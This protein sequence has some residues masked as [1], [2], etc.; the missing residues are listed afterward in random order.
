MTTQEISNLTNLDTSLINFILKNELGEYVNKTLNKS[1]HILKSRQAT[2]PR[3]KCTRI[4]VLQS[5]T[6]GNLIPHPVLR[7]DLKTIDY[8]YNGNGYPIISNGSKG[9]PMEESPYIISPI[10]STNIAE[11]SEQDIFNMWK[12][13]ENNDSDLTMSNYEGAKSTFLICPDRIT[14]IEQRPSE[15]TSFLLV[16]KE[17]Y[18]KNK[19]S[20]YY[21]LLEPC[22]NIQSDAIKEECEYGKEK[23]SSE[24]DDELTFSLMSQIQC[25]YPNFNE[26]IHKKIRNLFKMRTNITDNTEDSDI[27]TLLNRTQV[28]FEGILKEKDVPLD[29]IRKFEDG[30]NKSLMSHISWKGIIKRKINNL[31]LNI[32]KDTI[33]G[34]LRDSIWKDVSTQNASLKALILRHLVNFVVYEKDK[35]NNWFIGLL[36][37]HNVLKDSMSFL[38]TV[39]NI[40]NKYDHYNREENPLSWSIEEFF[41]NVE[42]ILKILNEVYK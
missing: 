25:A 36:D 1:W 4:S 28:L 9:K 27:D 16:K 17:I 29:K 6:T 15:H 18:G 12:D 24:D 37:Y 23:D 10:N 39:A 20:L 26:H 22:C 7:S 5:L 13:Y 8:E 31:Y 34:L 11:I 40:R 2:N 32:D 19:E 35:E 33:E 3:I 41:K 42:K 14:S 38:V 30:V 21:D